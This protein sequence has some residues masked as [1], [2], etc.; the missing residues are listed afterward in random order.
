MSRFAEAR[1]QLDHAA[2]ADPLS[3]RLLVDLATWY[4]FQRKYQPAIDELQKAI[5]LDPNNG[6]TLEFM[7]Y[8]LLKNDRPTEAVAHIQR[9]ITLG[10]MFNA[11][12]LAELQR[13]YERE[14]A[15]AFLRKQA[16]F[17]QQMNNSGKYYSPLLIGLIYAAAGDREPAFQWLEKA[18]AEHAPWL[19]EMKLEPTYDVLRSDPRF[20]QMLKK[21]GLEK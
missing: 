8:M 5:E 3:V 21:V 13:T 2:K 15:S 20:S 19:P 11:Q 6:V 16:D 7:G 10:G 4:W 14:G 1:E 18:V 9:A 12:Q 17:A